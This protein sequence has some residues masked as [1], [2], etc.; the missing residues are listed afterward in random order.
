LSEKYAKDQRRASMPIVTA[1][2][3]DIRKHFGADS[4]VAIKASENGQKIE[5]RKVE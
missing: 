2:V 4:I 1:F 5:W 3:D